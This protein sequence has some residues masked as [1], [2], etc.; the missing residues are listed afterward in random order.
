MERKTE[1]QSPRNSADLLTDPGEIARVE[2]QNALQQFD[3]AM[4][5]VEA[6]LQSKGFKLERGI[7]YEL[8]RLA[9][10]GIKFNAGKPRQVPIRIDGSAH[11]PPEWEDVPAY[12]DELCRYVNEQWSKPP[13]HLAAYLLWRLNWIH[14][15]EDGNG[16]TARMV[17]YMVLC[18]RLG[19][20]LPGTR[21]I[22]EQIASN[23]LP[24]YNALEA[25]D[26][27]YAQGRI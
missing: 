1:A 24:Y 22:P 4:D 11:Q 2:S 14:P 7:L 25:A 19:F 3:F 27:E 21:T 26:A 16:R 17:S 13:I 10:A 15:F 20:V 5:F 12:V 6:V 8:N 9:T 23:K 18:I